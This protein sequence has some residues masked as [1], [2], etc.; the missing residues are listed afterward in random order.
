M[1]Y[2]SVLGFSMPNRHWNQYIPNQNLWDFIEIYTF[3]TN[4]YENLL[5]S[6][7]FPLKSM[8]VCWNLYIFNWNLWQSIEVYTLPIETY[9]NLLKSI[10]FQLK[11]L[12]SYW[13]LT[14]LIEIFENLLKYTF[15]GNFF[16]KVLQFTFPVEIYDNLLK[17]VHFLLKPIKI[18]G[19]QCFCT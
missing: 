6:I 19:N 18:Y 8:K 9:D 3:L 10:H 17:S 11:S 13:H 14:F 16:E 15:V 5:K 7:H 12:K 2:L 1:V 4:I